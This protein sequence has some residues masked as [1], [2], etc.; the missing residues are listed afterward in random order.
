MNVH[1]F[2]DPVSQIIEFSI[3]GLPMQ[4]QNF[5]QVGRFFF[6]HYFRVSDYLLNIFFANPLGL[7]GFF[8]AN[9]LN[10]FFGD[11][12]F[13]AFSFERMIL[14]RRIPDDDIRSRLLNPDKYIG[15][16]FD[17]FLFLLEEF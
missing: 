4:F 2:F 17:R 14:W 10:N 12:L 8:S 16:F 3:H 7:L 1:T 11:I 15:T 5:F 13:F 9:S 6:P